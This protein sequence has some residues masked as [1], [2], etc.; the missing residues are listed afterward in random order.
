MAKLEVDGLK[1]GSKTL[2]D[3][4]YPV[5]SI[6]MSVNETNPATLFGGGGSHYQI[7]FF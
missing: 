7:D 3:L 6:Y 1:V 2:L 5:G 4:T